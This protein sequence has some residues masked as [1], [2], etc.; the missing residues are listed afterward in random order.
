MIEPNLFQKE[1]R[2]KGMHLLPTFLAPFLFLL[3][4]VFFSLRVVFL[5]ILFILA[6]LSILFA[7]HEIGLKNGFA[8]KIP[9]ASQV[10]AV[11]KRDYEIQNRTFIGA[12]LYFTTS[13]FLF[14][15]VHPA[16][17]IIAFSVSALADAVAA[18]IGMKYGKIR[19]PLSKNKTIEGS[20][21]FFI[22]SS[23][24]TLLLILLLFPPLSISFTNL[25]PIIFRSLLVSLAGAFLEAIS[26]PW[27]LDQ[28][29]VPL[30]IGI[31]LQLLLEQS[32]FYPLILFI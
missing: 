20:L 3:F 23:L 4:S 13:F 1:L 30:T 18:L 8:N 31:T 32:W 15:L 19:N 7:I 10:F 11:M 16:I 25:L 21:S 17:G 14:L 5:I 28:V 26:R 27:Y 24:Y 6:I 22:S 12:P 9:F 29:T 2:R